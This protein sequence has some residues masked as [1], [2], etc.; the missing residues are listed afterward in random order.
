MTE[1]QF[2]FT[3]MMADIAKLRAQLTEIYRTSPPSTD[4]EKLGQMI[5]QI[6]QGTTQAE[7]AY[8]DFVDAMTKTLH[9]TRAD[10]MKVQADAAELETRLQARIAEDE[11]KAAMP[12]A[13]KPAPTE[14]GVFPNL[15]QE[16]GEELLS[17]F[18]KAKQ[19]ADGWK[20]AGSVHELWLEPTDSGRHEIPKWDG[21]TI[22]R[23]ML[24][25]LTL[26]KA[27]APVRPNRAVSEDAWEDWDNWDDGK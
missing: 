5:A 21:P 11:A 6:E 8:P 14:P 22:A 1:P 9:Q 26:L 10:A 7:K 25:A 19:A 2:S 20:D 18:G 27:M 17:R 13:P 12:G 24:E 4:R 15:H 3:A 16:L 23:E